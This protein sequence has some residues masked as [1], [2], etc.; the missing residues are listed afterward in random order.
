MRQEIL[1]VL[2]ALLL[3]GLGTYFYF[4]SQDAALEPQEAVQ[5]PAPEAAGEPQIRHPLPEAEAD[6]PLPKLNESD[7]PLH[8]ALVGVVG[9][10]AVAQYL[11]PQEVIRH[12]VVTI[13]NLPRKKIALDLRPVKATAGRFVASGGGESVV[14]DSE[15]FARY[16]P[17]VRIVQT[18]D[19]KQVAAV[20]RRFYPLFQE[21]YENLGY[22]SAYFND[23][24]IEVID[25]LLETPEVKS[26]IKLVQPRV[27]YQFA[28]P[29]LESRSAGQ[30]LLIRMGSE[31][32]EAI[33]AKLREIR[34]EIAGGAQ[35]L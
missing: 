10:G 28:D 32:A 26:P 34:T 4:Q 2:G 23:R 19:T 33:K 15:N 14:L 13:D 7:Q 5:G 11:V 12:F 18:A 17:L 30:K 6:A 29:A 27:F 8:D 9:E 24:L 20:Y 22:P 25:H 31:N 3:A 1:W 21:A 16:T 35:K